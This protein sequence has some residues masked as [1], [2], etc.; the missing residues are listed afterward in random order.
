MPDRAWDT[1]V[2]VANPARIKAA[3]GWTPRFT[4]ADG[5]AAFA[6][7]LRA[8]VEHHERYEVGL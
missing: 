5:F 1:N 4:F 8:A 7:W 3:L 2:W 6:D